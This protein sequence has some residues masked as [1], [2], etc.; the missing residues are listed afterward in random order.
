[1][2]RTRDQQAHV[3]G[4]EGGHGPFGELGR[5]ARD[6]VHVGPGG[7]VVALLQPELVVLGGGLSG[8]GE[9][10]AAPL[11]EELAELCLFPVRVETSRLG[12]ESV[13][14]GAVRLA[15]DHVEHALFGV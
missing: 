11:R 13:A 10:L 15:L 5:V 7:A 8:A 6:G 4:G 1:M 2:Y 14:L 3:A 9:L 12:S